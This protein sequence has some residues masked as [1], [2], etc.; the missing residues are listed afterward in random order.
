MQWPYLIPTHVRN[1]RT[2]WNAPH[3][4]GK[5]A[6]S[7]HFT[8]SVMVCKQLHS[9]TDT[10]ERF[11]LLCC[12]ANRIIQTSLLHPCHRRSTR[13]DTRQHY[14]LS[15]VDHF[16]F[17]SDLYNCSDMFQ[18]LLNTTNIACAVIDNSNH[19]SITAQAIFVVL[20]RRWNISEQ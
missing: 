9:K 2:M 18:R 3:L 13:A 15:L 8:F 11:A 10:K 5:E 12:L 17:I 4:A 7:V 16:R 14:C 19:N 1:L 20:R 6:Q